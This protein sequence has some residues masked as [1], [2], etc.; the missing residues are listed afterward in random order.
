MSQA[1]HRSL[2]GE[3]SAADRARLNERLES[4]R[5]NCEQR[6]RDDA[7]MRRTLTIVQF[8][9]VLVALLLT[10]MLGGGRWIV[11]HAVADALI[12]SG[13]IVTVPRR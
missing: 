2:L 6:H 7:A 5:S 4:L 9:G 11:K 3:D 13:V 12:E 8:L 10:T 1:M